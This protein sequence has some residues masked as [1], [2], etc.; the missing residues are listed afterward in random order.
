[1]SATKRFVR[2]A[3][4]SAPQTFAFGATMVAIAAVAV[5]S[6]LDRQLTNPARQ[7]NVSSFARSLAAL[8]KPSPA[9]PSAWSWRSDD[10]T[11]GAIRQKPPYLN[12]I[13]DPSL[14]D[15]FRKNR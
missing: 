8:P 11:V 4:G 15:P 10:T 1:M 5:T 7:A 6:W 2:D 14:G 13:D 9:A 3:R 12:T